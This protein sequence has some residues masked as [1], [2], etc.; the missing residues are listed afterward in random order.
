MFPLKSRCF[1]IAFK[2]TPNEAADGVSPCF[3]PNSTLNSSVFL[4]FILTLALVLI[5]INSISTHKNYYFQTSVYARYILESQI[6]N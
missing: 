4:L 3:T 2:T 1:N 6:L 5:R